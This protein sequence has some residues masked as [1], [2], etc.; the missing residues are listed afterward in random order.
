VGA[1]KL[2]QPIDSATFF[3][4]ESID[5]PQSYPLESP[6]FEN[7]NPLSTVKAI[8]T[9]SNLFASLFGHTYY[10]SSRIAAG[11]SA[12]FAALPEW[13]QPDAAEEACLGDFVPHIRRILEKAPVST[14]VFRRFADAPPDASLRTADTDYDQLTDA[15][16]EAVSKTILNAL[17]KWS[18]FQSL[19]GAE[20]LKHS[21]TGRQA[22][23]R[24]EEAFEQ[25]LALD[26]HLRQGGL[27]AGRSF[28]ADISQK[29][30]ATFDVA[31]IKPSLL[32]LGPT[33]AEA[34][35]QFDEL[36]IPGYAVIDV[37]AFYKSQEKF[38]TLDWFNSVHA[39]A[40]SIQPPNEMHKLLARAAI[41]RASNFEWREPPIPPRRI[42]LAPSTDSDF[43]HWA[44]LL[45]MVH[46]LH[47]AGYQRIR[48][49]PGIGGIGAWRC[50]ITSADN[51]E[52]DGFTIKHLD[53]DGGLVA[54]YSGSDGAHYFNWTDG[55]MMNARQMAERFL[56]AFPRITSAGAGRDWMYA[57]WLT[58]VLGRA[59]QGTST[60]II[61][62]YNYNNAGDAPDDDLELWSP[63]PL[64]S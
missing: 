32:S 49:N 36:M 7:A 8:M 24:G 34:V 37:A 31:T 28:I 15:E 61:K 6:L 63:P 44:R 57:G 45:A 20:Q 43:R 26:C 55:P 4:N 25:L 30:I 64:R 50:N 40:A 14:L 12:S 54:P 51:T 35:T 9:T 18:A 60:D 22:L 46:E 21:S 39:E 48:I 29:W 2:L 59:E 47:K 52:A 62:L 17:V 23:T 13:Y 53:F 1:T 33:M 56:H 5:Y 41:A 3:P 42:S 11:I 16:Q 38:E 27:E 19:N 10:L 58:D